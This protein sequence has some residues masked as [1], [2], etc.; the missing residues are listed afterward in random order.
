MLNTAEKVHAG[1]KITTHQDHA[2]YNYLTN[3]WNMSKG[4]LIRQMEL[5]QMEINRQ[6][7]EKENQTNETLFYQEKVLE[8]QDRILKHYKIEDKPYMKVA[9]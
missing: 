9:Q 7:K 4:Q 3:A 8:L 2:N 5:M 1:N 6:N